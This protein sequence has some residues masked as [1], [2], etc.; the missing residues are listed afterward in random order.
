MAEAQMHMIT[1]NALLDV[2][3]RLV[4][5]IAVDERRKY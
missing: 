1:A 2:A 3:S 5:D 4:L